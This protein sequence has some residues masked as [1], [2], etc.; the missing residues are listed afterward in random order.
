M[1]IHQLFATSQPG[2]PFTFVVSTEGMNRKGFRINQNGWDLSHFLANPIALW[3]HDHTMPIGRWEDVQ[4]QG[5][6][7]V[8]K[9]KLAAQGTSE[10]IDGIRGLLEQGILKATSVGFRVLDYVED[11]KTKELTVTKAE[12]REISIVTVP[13]DP[14]A[15]RAM[16]NLSAEVRDRILMPRSPSGKTADTP[17]LP[18]RNTTMTLAERIR[19]LEAEL[20]EKK[21]RL[22]TLAEQEELSD[23]ESSELD[24]LSEEAETLGTKLNSLKRAEAAL[25]SNAKQTRP[26]GK[27]TT[28]AQARRE[29]QK[30]ELLFRGA[31][32]LAKSHVTNRSV[33]DIVLSEFGGD[34]ELEMMTLAAANPAMTNVAGWASDLIETQMGEFLD[35]LSPESVFARMAGLRVSFD[36]NGGVKLPGRATRSLGGSF[37]GEGAPI[38]VRQAQ[39]NTVLLSPF[40]ATVITTMT[41]ELAQRS[42]P[43]AE[44]LFRQMLIEDTAI[45]IDAAFMDDAAASAVRAAGLQVLG[46]G[47]ASAGNSVTQIMTDLRGMAEDLILAQAGR[48]P[49]WIMNDIRR[50]GLMTALS[51]TEDTRPFA[52]EVRGGSLLGYPIVT[53]I[54]VP[55]DV[56]F[57]VD[58]AELAQGYGDSPVIDMSNQA[59]LH[60]EDTT[61]LPLAS[62]TQGSAVVAT[63]M[64]SLFQTDSLALRLIWDVSWVLRRA[65]ACQFRTG[66]AW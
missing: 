6:R 55:N 26:G 59:T 41:R 19:A 5:G 53:S 64:R 9:L 29:R 46:T 25:A 34:K 10:F 1:K 47:S 36:R 40:K 3:M 65:G 39:L 51:T 2:D 18:K 14:G 45:T 16:Q 30:A 32:V 8:A 13:A 57:L 28:P 50:L 60:M 61:P 12:L 23:E 7:L 54:N 43:A 24:T 31:F 20:N 22:T 17:P 62:G 15:L 21:A 35:L 63:P 52:D 37:T 27:T 44:P 48:R 42:A 49:V 11:K 4:I 58:Q 56:V 33:Q 38:P 66:V